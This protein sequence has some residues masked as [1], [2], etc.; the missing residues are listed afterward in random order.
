MDTKSDS[1]N[2]AYE[3]LLIE[4]DRIRKE[5][6]I[7]RKE[8]DELSITIKGLRVLLFEFEKRLKQI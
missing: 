2:R 1:F 5:M 6:V 4:N 3:Q 8:N 7:L